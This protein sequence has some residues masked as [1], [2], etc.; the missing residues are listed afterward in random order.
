MINFNFIFVENP[1]NKMFVNHKIQNII[2]TPTKLR[3]YQEL[4]PYEHCACEKT[5]N[6]KY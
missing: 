3:Y 2:K 6:F 4:H 5:K 1:N